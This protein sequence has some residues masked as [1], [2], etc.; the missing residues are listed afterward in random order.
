MEV[1]VP[2]L[3]RPCLVDATFEMSLFGILT[4][5]LLVPIQALCFTYWAVAQRWTWPNRVT[6]TVR[7]YHSSTTI[8]YLDFSVLRLTN[9]GLAG[10]RENIH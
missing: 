5:A 1:G 6:P 7:V 8:R 3:I 10:Y 4:I 2:K 9:S